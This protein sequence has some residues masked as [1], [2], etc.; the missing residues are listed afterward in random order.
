M[1][2]IDDMS[3]GLGVSNEIDIAQ[4]YDCPTISFHTSHKHAGGAWDYRAE[5]HAYADGKLMKK[6]LRVSVVGSLKEKR[7]AHMKEAQE[8]AAKRFGDSEWV[9]TGLP[10][11]WMPKDAKDR[12]KVDLQEWRAQN[13]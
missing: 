11:S 8:W 13:A 3:S 4:R 5:I 7:D 12:M 1:S 6:T 2:Y 9:P 10:N